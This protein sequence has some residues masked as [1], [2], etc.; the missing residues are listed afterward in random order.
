MEKLSTKGI[1]FDVDDR[2]G[3]EGIKHLI[4]IL[5]TSDTFTL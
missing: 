1:N 2:L 4:F 5:E 3:I